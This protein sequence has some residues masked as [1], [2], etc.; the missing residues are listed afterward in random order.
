MQCS[1]AVTDT[2]TQGE[3]LL[4]EHGAAQWDEHSVKGLGS[5]AL[6]WAV[7]QDDGLA[8]EQLLLGLL[9]AFWS[10]LQKSLQQERDL[11]QP[12]VF[13]AA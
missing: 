12:A 4:G 10:H 11:K 8:G 5:P 1:Q 2:G 9:A 6:G 13:P 7:V 3:M